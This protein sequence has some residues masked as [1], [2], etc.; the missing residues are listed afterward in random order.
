M[1]ISVNRTKM[2]SFAE[3]ISRHKGHSGKFI[4]C[5]IRIALK[6]PSSVLDHVKLCLL[7]LCSDLT[8][9][10]IGLRSRKWEEISVQCRRYCNLEESFG[11]VDA[12]MRC[13]PIGHLGPCY[14]GRFHASSDSI[15]SHDFGGARQLQNDPVCVGIECKFSC[16]HEWFDDW[17]PN[18]LQLY[19]K[20]RWGVSL[21]PISMKCVQCH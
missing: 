2:E 10:L 6:H 15:E 19:K 17:A 13:L 5:G 14:A 11:R 3:L 7:N 20:R 4:A 8:S 1:Y 16:V 12:L 21:A 18:G 9:H